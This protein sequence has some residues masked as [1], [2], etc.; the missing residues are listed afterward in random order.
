[1]IDKKRLIVDNIGIN[2]TAGM[3]NL[4]AEE[5]HPYGFVGV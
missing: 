1:M 3:Y 2:S 4:V 5:L